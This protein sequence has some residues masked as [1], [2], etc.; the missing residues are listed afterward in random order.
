MF[1]TASSTIENA[2]AEISKMKETGEI[3]RPI[4]FG[5][6]EDSLFVTSDKT[7]IRAYDVV[8]VDGIMYYIGFKTDLDSQ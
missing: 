8:E 5:E 1:N 3:I 4:P 7:L 6:D 2:K